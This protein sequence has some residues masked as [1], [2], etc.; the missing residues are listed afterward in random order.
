MP[1]L[2]SYERICEPMTA[3]CVYL[4]YRRNQHPRPFSKSNTNVHWILALQEVEELWLFSG[5]GSYHCHH[6]IVVV[7][8]F[9]RAQCSKEAVVIV[10][11][12][13]LF[14]ITEVR[15]FEKL[16]AALLQR[17][18]PLSSHL[19]LDA[20]VI[21]PWE[22]ENICEQDFGKNT[23]ESIRKTKRLALQT[24]FLILDIW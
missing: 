5:D 2:S 24:H 19:T 10:F 23:L 21:F 9:V 20:G 14:H 8:L 15:G 1:V 18:R 4:I 17:T 16:V 12:Q 6:G 7:C 13:R 22:T 3:S 11:V